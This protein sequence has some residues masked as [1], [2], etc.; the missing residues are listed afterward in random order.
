MLAGIVFELFAGNTESTEIMFAFVLSPPLIN[1]F[2]LLKL[3]SPRTMSL[4]KSLS[5]SI[6]NKVEPACFCLALG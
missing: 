5:I 4:S 1:K 6:N 3:I 2:K